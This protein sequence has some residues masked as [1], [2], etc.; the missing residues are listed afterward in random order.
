MHTIF[1]LDYLSLTY[2]GI[3]LQLIYNYITGKIMRPGGNPLEVQGIN[4]DSKVFLELFLEHYK[5][6]SAVTFVK[7]ILFIRE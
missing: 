2:N 4:S 3:M 6:R 1:L 5:Y 7:A